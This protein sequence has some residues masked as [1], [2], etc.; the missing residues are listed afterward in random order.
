MKYDVVIGIET[1]IQLNTQSKMFCGCSTDSW[2]AEPNT[3]VCPVC[4]GLPGALPLANKSALDKAMLV[5]AALGAT[6][7]DYCKFDRKNYFYPDLAKGYQISQYDQPLNSGGSVVVDGTSIGLIRAHLE[8]DVGKLTH[9][10]SYS[11]VDFNKGG[12][13][14][15]EIVSEPTIRSASQAKAYVQALRQIVRYIGVNDGNLERGVMRADVNISLQEPGK[16]QYQDG[17]FVV[18]DN[19]T[20]NNRTEIKNLNSFRSIERAIVYEISRQA[21]LLETGK[22]IAQETRGWDDAKGVT[23]SQRTKEEAHD[24]RYFPEPDLPP[25]A[26]S[27]QWQ[28]EIRHQLPELPASK[29]QRF[30]A[31]YGLSEYDTRLLVEERGVAEWYEEAVAVYLSNAGQ[32]ANNH[33]LAKAVANWVLGEIA[34]LQNENQNYVY[35]SKLRPTQLAEVLELV[36]K[37]KLSGASAKELVTALYTTEAKVDQVVANRGLEQVS[38]SSDLEPIARK[39]IADNPDAVGKVRAGKTA[40]IQFLVGQVMRETRGRANPTTVSELLQQLLK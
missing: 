2:R 31:E 22:P 35:Q 30:M 4:L 15:L 16:W 20:L 14:L 10:N 8:E 26:I 12:I 27:K 5:G 39:V 24:Y 6:I 7:A 13:P 34:R 21:K 9:E 1:H 33:K 3:R 17:Q 11:L 37:G 18:A 40:T 28:N 32:A 29:Q 19:Y 38:G 36:D 25:L 23:T